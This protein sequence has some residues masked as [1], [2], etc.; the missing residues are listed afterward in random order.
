MTQTRG[1]MSEDVRTAIEACF[2]C[3]RACLEAQQHL[4]VVDGDLAGPEPMNILLDCAEVC[5]TTGSLLIRGSARQLLMA[6]LCA[7]VCDECADQ[8][9]AT[10]AGDDVLLRCAAE[11]RACA[12]ACRDLAGGA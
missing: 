2:R 11:C 10:A 8:W 4:I 9:D 3:H 6:D 12:A 7:T 5:H 1:S